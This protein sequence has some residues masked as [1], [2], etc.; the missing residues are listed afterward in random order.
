[1]SAGTAAGSERTGRLGQRVWTYQGVYARRPLS[2]FFA[3][4]I[5]FIVMCTLVGEYYD[6]ESSFRLVFWAV[7]VAGVLCFALCVRH[8]H[9]RIREYEHGFELL[10]PGRRTLRYAWQ[11]IASVESTR[12]SVHFNFAHSHDVLKTVI[13]PYTGDR[14]RVRGLDY[15]KVREECGFWGLI[16]QATPDTGERFVTIAT[17]AVGEARAQRLVDEL[18]A[19]GAFR[20]GAL[21][22]TAEGMTLAPFAEPVAWSRIALVSATPANGVLLDV[23]GLAAHVGSQALRAQAIKKGYSTDGDQLRVFVPVR[24]PG[25]DY[26]ALSIL[27]AYGAAVHGG[28]DEGR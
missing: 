23:E 6:E 15:V 20:W 2:A 1:M 5:A 25:S 12:V 26:L 24:R 16:K 11:E 27:L 9:I 21:T 7:V 10:R 17:R 22:F 4:L 8:A 14:I 3:L 13:R 18:G 19:G 28:T